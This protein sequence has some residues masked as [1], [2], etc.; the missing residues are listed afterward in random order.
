MNVEGRQPFDY[1]KDLHGLWHP[2]VKE[3]HISVYAANTGVSQRQ[4]LPSP[5][6]K[7]RELRPYAR[8]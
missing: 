2:G 3:P 5:D 7:A 6:P 4:A 1:L 8:P